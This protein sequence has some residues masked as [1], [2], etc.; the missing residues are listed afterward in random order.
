MNGIVVATT[1]APQSPAFRESRLG[2]ATCIGCDRNGARAAIARLPMEERLRGHQFR[3]A[4]ASAQRQRA[5]VSF[6][7]HA[8]LDLLAS[9]P[10]RRH[11]SFIWRT[12]TGAP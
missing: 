1:S 10:R 12:I 2:P 5:T 9:P 3:R 11:R 4:A 7:A 6:A 8:P